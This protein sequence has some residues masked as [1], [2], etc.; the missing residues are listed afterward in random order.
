MENDFL[1]PLDC[2]HPTS[3]VLVYILYAKGICWMLSAGR[4]PTLWSI[5]AR[6]YA[7][8][9]TLEMDGDAIQRTFGP[10]MRHERNLERKGGSV[11]EWWGV[12]E[13][14]RPN[15]QILSPAVSGGENDY[16]IIAPGEKK[17][18]TVTHQELVTT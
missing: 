6:L 3:F 5:P 8:F 13:G 9:N 17:T 12:E 10:Y 11:G 2:S 18:H 1:N 4:S 15:M 16:S 7:G 14:R